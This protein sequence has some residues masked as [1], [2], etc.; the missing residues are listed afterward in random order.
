MVRQF[1]GSDPF[2]TEELEVLPQVQSLPGSEGDQPMKGFSKPVSCDYRFSYPARNY[3]RVPQL[4]VQPRSMG[5]DQ[6]SEGAG[7]GGKIE[8]SLRALEVIPAGE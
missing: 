4:G 7:A 6:F 8:K 2:A 3:G 1:C 5:K